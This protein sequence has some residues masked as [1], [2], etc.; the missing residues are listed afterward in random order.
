MMQDLWDIMN[1][2]D[3]WMHKVNQG[4]LR[5]TNNQQHNL[6]IPA[7]QPTRRSRYKKYSIFGSYKTKHQWSVV[8]ESIMCYWKEFK[9]RKYKNY[10]KDV[11]KFKMDTSLENIMAS[12]GILYQ[13]PLN[14][15]VF[16]NFRHDFILVSYK[17]TNSIYKTMFKTNFAYNLYLFWYKTNI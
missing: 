5:I 12:I 2:L 15:C 1:A 7:H 4:I 8:W 14:L 11:E 17:L 10:S 16:I 13:F 9:S 3:F 6:D